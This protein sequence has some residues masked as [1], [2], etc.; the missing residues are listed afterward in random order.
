MKTHRIAANS[1][2]STRRRVREQLQKERRVSLFANQPQIEI[3]TTMERITSMSEIMDDILLNEPQRYRTMISLMVFLIIL[4]MTGILGITGIV[5]TVDTYIYSPTSATQTQSNT[6]T[7]RGSIGMTDEKNGNTGDEKQPTLPITQTSKIDKKLDE[8]ESS[9]HE[10][11]Q[12]DEEHDIQP[13]HVN[14]KDIESMS[15][16]DIF[17]EIQALESKLKKQEEE[18]RHKAKTISNLK[19]KLNPK[20]RADIDFQEHLFMRSTTQSDDNKEE[21][22][23]SSTPPVHTTTAQISRDKRDE[24]ES[25]LRWFQQMI[26][27]SGYTE[28]QKERVLQIIIRRKPEC[29]ELEL[30]SQ[31]CKD[32]IDSDIGSMFTGEEYY[33]GWLLKI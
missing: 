18:K 6:K 17:Q 4:G 24:I 7:L 20:L 5:L 12:S 10:T 26:I 21:D 29:M 16:I 22:D 33:K 23:W 2:P 11:N 30:T 32:I 15:L 8:Y 1:F 28:G 3:A 13:E 19:G 14:N 9:E 25:Y 27:E 31:E